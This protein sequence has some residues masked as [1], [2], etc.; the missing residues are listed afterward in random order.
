MKKHLITFL[1]LLLIGTSYAQDNFVMPDSLKVLLRENKGEDLNR[2]NALARVN[3]ALLR[4]GYYNQSKP[5]ITELSTIAKKTKNNYIKAMAEYYESSLKF[6]TT[7]DYKECIDPLLSAKSYL[8]TMNDTEDVLVYKIRILNLMGICY[9]R[10]QL[11]TEA[12]QCYETG[13]ELCKDVKNENLESDIMQNLIGLHG[14]MKSYEEQIKLDKDFINNPNFNPSRKILFY[15]DIIGSYMSLEKYDSSMMYL[16]ALDTLVKTPRDKAMVNAYYGCNY[17]GLKQYEQAITKFHESLNTEEITDPQIELYSYGHLSNSF[18]QLKNYDSAFYYINKTIEKAKEYELLEWEVNGMG[19]KCDFLYELKRFEE[20][21]ENIVVYNRLN[22]SL[23]HIRNLNDL[24]KIMLQKQY[25]EMEEQLKSKLEENRI[26][27][28]KMTILFIILGSLA[29]IAIILL[30]LNRKSILL[31]NKEMKEESLSKELEMRNRELASNVVI[32]MKKNEVFADIIQ[33][34]LIIKENTDK[35]ETRE[36]IA[37]VTKD[38][39]KTIEGKFWEE[40]ELRF[41]N[42][43]SDFYQRLMQQFPDLTT[44]EVR[45]CSFLKLGLSTK[46]ICSITGQTVPSIEKARNRLRKKL[47]IANDPNINMTSFIQKI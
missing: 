27:Q 41:K 2:A 4:T 15:G 16:Q 38:I 25:Q 30:L 42:V 1:L 19:Q 31:K 32:L 39:E 9:S 24:D 29:A 37:K 8:E 35:E 44:S 47:G 28:Y 13:L 5:Y 22:D 20:F 40:F 12:F 6:F 43:Y 46:D 21:S 14:M 33:R 3:D 36:A 23:N 26:K 7:A 11:F 10:T 17:N 45:L 34:L 18:Y